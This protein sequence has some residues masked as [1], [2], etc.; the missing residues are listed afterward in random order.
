MTDKP[1]TSTNQVRPQESRTQSGGSTPF[2]NSSMSPAAHPAGGDPVRRD[3]GGKTDDPYKKTD[4]SKEIDTSAKG[5]ATRLGG[6]NDDAGEGHKGP[7]TDATTE[8]SDNRS[9]GDRP[10]A[11]TQPTRPNEQGQSIERGNSGADRST[12]GKEPEVKK[13]NS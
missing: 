4:P 6:P 7:R 12:L 13:S 9:Q 2:G 11:W 8:R 10:N 5:N 3:L 1:A